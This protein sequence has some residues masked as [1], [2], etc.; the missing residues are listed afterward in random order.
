[1]RLWELKQ[2]RLLYHIWEQKIFSQNLKMTSN[3]FYL[4]SGLKHT[5]GVIGEQTLI[6]LVQKPR[7]MIKIQNQRIQWFWTCLFGWKETRQGSGLSQLVIFFFHGGEKKSISRKKLVRL[8]FYFQINYFGHR[9]EN[10]L[11][12][13]ATLLSF[14]FAWG[15]EK[16]SFG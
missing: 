11:G 4:K 2:W 15:Q 7:R 14:S 5:A 10:S 13:K 9:Q 8:Y 16:K 6:L 1:M 12:T 3:I